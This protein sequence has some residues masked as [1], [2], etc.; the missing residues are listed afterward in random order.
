[1]K[2]IEHVYAIKN[3]LNNGP[4]S[5][6]TSFTDRLISH[7][8]QVA[9]AVLLERK[10]DKY[11]YISEQSYQ[12]LCV[13]LELSSFHNCCDTPDLDCKVLKSVDPIP[14]FLNSR[15]GNYLKTMDL[16]GTVIPEFNLTQSRH[17]KYSIIKPT[18]GWFLHDNHLYVINN[19]ALAKVLLN[20]LFDNPEEIYE[21]N[22]A[23]TGDNNCPEYL[24]QVFPID[25]DLIDAMYKMTIDMLLRMYSVPNDLENNA[26]NVQATQAIQ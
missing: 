9:R 16:T 10:I 22:C 15:W 3:V 2:L 7:Y 24:D 19:T 14:K 5:I 21:Y 6:S 4:A 8:L 26:K 20:A 17:S 12:S 18:T 23:S 13:D 11:Y 25:S 1:M